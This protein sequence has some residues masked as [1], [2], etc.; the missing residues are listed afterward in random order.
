MPFWV[1]DLLLATSRQCNTRL[2]ATGN[3]KK[4]DTK[5]RFHPSSSA[6]LPLSHSLSNLLFL[7][8]FLA[9][10]STQPVAIGKNLYL[11]GLDLSW[12][13]KPTLNSPSKTSLAFIGLN[14]SVTEYHIIITALYD[15]V[16][17]LGGFL[18]PQR[19]FGCRSLG[20]ATASSRQRP[21]MLLNILQYI[22]KQRIIWPKM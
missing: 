20:V 10:P 18:P 2:E 3:S 16:R 14:W 11:R 13:E 6:I 5:G 15:V 12:S 9:Q 17:V 8:P 19:T 7:Q 21:R 4:E 1:L 22:E